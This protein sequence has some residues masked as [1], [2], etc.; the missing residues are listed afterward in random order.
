MACCPSFRV[1]M[2]SLYNKMLFCC[3]WRNIET[4]CHKHFVVV[5][6]HQPTLPLITAR[7]V[8]IALTMPWQDVCL[9]V[10]LSDSLSHDGIL[11]INGYIHILK[12]FFSPSGSRTSLVSR[13]K[14]NG[15]TSTGTPLTRASNTRWYEKITIFDQY[16]ALYWKLY[17]IEL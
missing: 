3:L 17:K 9:S 12:D 14:L 6:G 2:A 16:L 4:S 10:R 5:S 15:N 7:R 8:C 1:C 11:C 13:T